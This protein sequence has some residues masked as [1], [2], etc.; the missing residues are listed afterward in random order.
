MVPDKGDAYPAGCYRRGLVRPPVPKEPGDAHVPK[1]AEEAEGFLSPRS[2]RMPMSLSRLAIS[3]KGYCPQADENGHVP[4]Q[5]EGY[6]FPEQPEDP[7]IPD[8]A[9]ISLFP[10]RHSRIL[11][12]GRGE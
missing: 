10:C 5:V 8:Q 3:R 2:K 4:K 12:P 1:Q 11:S 9:Q 7:H 6:T